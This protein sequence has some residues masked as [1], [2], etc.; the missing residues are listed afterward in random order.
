MVLDNPGHENGG[1]LDPRL[2]KRNLGLVTRPA[3]G[4]D[5]DGLDIEIVCEQR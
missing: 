2:D 3:R 1:R 5:P 4:S